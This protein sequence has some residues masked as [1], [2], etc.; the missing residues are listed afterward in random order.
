M[1]KADP[2]IRLRKP[3]KSPADLA[4]ADAFVGVQPLPPPA[5][6]PAAMPEM[7]PTAA[8]ARQPAAEP[9][10]A[11]AVMPPPPAMASVEPT[12]ITVPR[13]RTLVQRQDGRALHRTTIYMPPDLSRQL[14]LRAAQTNRTQSDLIEEALRRYL[15]SSPEP[16]NP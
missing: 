4:A 12:Y 14:A 8:P 10:P 16:W 15:Q 5:L 9:P 1:G 11:V 2:V 6:A 7:Q 3:P 13:R